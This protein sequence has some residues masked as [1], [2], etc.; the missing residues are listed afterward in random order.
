MN[1]HRRRGISLGTITMFIVTFAVLAGFVAL[2][3]TLTGN[4]DIRLEAAELVVAFDES[5]SQIAFKP[6][7]QPAPTQAPTS[8]LVPVFSG[9]T[10]ATQAPA[11]TA[12]PKRSFTLCATGSIVLNAAVQKALTVDGTLRFDLLTDQIPGAMNADLS[13]ATLENTIIPSQ[14]ASNLNMPQELLAALRATGINALYLGHPDVLNSGMSGLLETRQAVSDAGFLPYGLYTSAQEQQSGVMLT[15]GGVKV[16]M[17]SY[18]DQLSSTGRKKISKE[19]LSYAYSEP[20]I[21]RIAADISNAKQSGAEVIIVSLCWGKVGADQPSD[22]QTRLAQQMADAGADII[23]G[24]HSGALQPVHVLSANRGDQKY[25]PVLCAYSLGNLVTHD[26]DKRANLASILL[27]TNV[28]YDPSTGTVAF[29]N[30]GYT[31]TY[32][33]RGKEEGKTRYR[34]LLNDGSPLPAFVDQDQRGVME[35]CDKLVSEIMSN[36]AIPM[37][38]A[39]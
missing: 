2:L 12:V 9:N 20:D 4:Q 21:S 33:W 28:V 1:K 19:E 10:A 27:K 25:H 3:P 34:I 30:L 26:R 17:L 23:L 5:L 7:Q 18:Q 8:A 39:N 13:I 29:D 24:T 35:R 36:T 11:S 16:C 32:A 14:K 38:P 22:E 37:I 6:A 31:S 15:L